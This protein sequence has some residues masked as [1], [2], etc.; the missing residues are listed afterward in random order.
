MKAVTKAGEIVVDGAMVTITRRSV[1]GQGGDKRSVSL[2]SLTGVD[3]QQATALSPGHLRMIHPGNANSALKMR[4]YDRDTIMFAIE[5]QDQILPV[6][7]HLMSAITGKPFVADD[8]RPVSSAIVIP[9]LILA[10]AVISA[11][12]Y[13]WIM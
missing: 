11:F 12:A 10:I 9:Q 2:A 8:I 6:R 3:F 4:Y 7:G 13:A 5:E 1:L